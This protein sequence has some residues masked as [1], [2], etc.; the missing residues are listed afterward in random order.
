MTYQGGAAWTLI[1]VGWTQ[2]AIS[3]RVHCCIKTLGIAIVRSHVNV[4]PRGHCIKTPYTTQIT[5]LVLGHGG[6]I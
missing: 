2:V 4:S 3:S 1:T 5:L 6:A